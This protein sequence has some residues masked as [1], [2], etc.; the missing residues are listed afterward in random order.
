[1]SNKM[2][3]TNDQLQYYQSLT[4]NVTGLLFQGMYDTGMLPQYKQ[5][6]RDLVLLVYYRN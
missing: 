2:N 1:M 5:C 4:I 3:S 6:P